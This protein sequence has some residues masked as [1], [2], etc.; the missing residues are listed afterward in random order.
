M[1]N[2]F[3]TLKAG[4][5]MKYTDSH[6][7]IKLQGNIATLGISAF[8]QQEL[9]EI[10]YIEFPQVGEKINAGDEIA[11]LESTKAAADIYSPV[12]GRIVAINQDAKENANVVNDS[13]EGSGW[14]VQI[15]LADASELHK[16]LSKEAYNE[17][18]S[19]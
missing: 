18:I 6:E 11:V 8:A 1:V 3:S 2:N 9:G 7:W 19:V 4:K 14:L 15:E 10:V 16:L 13:P 12:S 17:L 5:D